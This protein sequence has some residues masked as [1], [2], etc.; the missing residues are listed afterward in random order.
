MF[1]TIYKVTNKINGKIYIGKHQT[2][3]LNDSYMGSGKLIRAAI[4]K[5]GLDNFE[6]EILFQFDNE[7]DMNKKEAELV[8]EEFV[9]E[10]TNYNLC[11]GGKGGWGYNN[12]KEGQKLREFSYSR[13]SK[14]GARSFKHKFE[15]D[16]NFKTQH[17]NMLEKASKKGIEAQKIKY[18]NG[19][20]YGKKH[21]EETKEKIGKANS[22]FQKG[23]NNSQ[24]GTMWITN[25]LES[26]KIKKESIIPDGWYKGRKI[27]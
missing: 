24:Y 10:N 18:P 23:E 25:G 1:Y 8:T 17:K 26:K 16:E 21:T 5:Y 3:D 19:V 14:A 9:E 12:T 22:E 20:F 7:A 6:K 4:E 27:K 15:T 13:W 2:K 11:P